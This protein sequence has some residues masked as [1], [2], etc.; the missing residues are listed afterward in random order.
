MT[1]R[2]GASTVPSTGTECEDQPMTDETAV[3]TGPLSAEYTEPGLPRSRRGHLTREA[4]QQAALEVFYRD[5]YVRARVSD[6]SAQAGV[7][8]GAFYRYFLDKRHVM[9]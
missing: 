3:A 9:V 7:S 1:S 6:I 2:Y 8:T 4:L 5:G